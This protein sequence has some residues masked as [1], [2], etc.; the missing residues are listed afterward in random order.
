MKL[1]IGVIGL[2]EAWESRHYPALRSLP[3]RFDVRAFATEVPCLAER[4][5]S[6]FQADAV[7]SFRHLA[8]RQDIDAVLI[9]CNEWYGPL[10]ILAA[11]DAGKAVYISTAL[12]IDHETAKTVKDRV[13]RSGVACMVELPRRHAAATLRLK[14]LIATRLGKPKLLFCHERMPSVPANGRVKRTR[15]GS[16]TRQIMESVDWCRYV[17]GQEPQSVVG[18]RHRPNSPTPSQETD[19]EMVSV[20]FT[21]PG[22]TDG[23]VAQISCGSYIHP[24][25]RGA[26]AFRAPAGLQVC[27]E[28][29][30]AFVDLPNSL[31]WFDH[32]GQHVESLESDRPVGEQLL[33]Q[34]YRAVTSLVRKPSDLEDAYRALEI[35]IAA[36]QGCTAG[37]RVSLAGD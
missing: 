6:E 24:H 16:S 13:D 5:A 27:C 1:R 8:S 23:A 18:V 12:D 19:Y 29:G 4:A 35:V 21:A 22:E 2:G 15:V 9:L 3:D 25:W 26:A 17:V 28:N 7:D 31:I 33:T 34:F 36:R 20:D 10:P 37:H 32:A 11:C 30:V 14:E